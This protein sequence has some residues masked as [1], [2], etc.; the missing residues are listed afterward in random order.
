MG[1]LVNAVLL[2]GLT[3][4]I[5][6]GFMGIPVYFLWN[7]LMPELFGFVRVTFLQAVGLC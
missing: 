6:S 2:I 1:K 4:V 3:C 7:W 5:V